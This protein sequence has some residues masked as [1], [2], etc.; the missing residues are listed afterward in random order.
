MKRIGVT[1]DETLLERLD[2]QP[3]VREQ[4]RATVLR[5]AVADYLASK[6]LEAT[7]DCDCPNLDAVE[8]YIMEEDLDTAAELALAIWCESCRSSVE[9]A[10]AATIRARERAEMELDFTAEHL[11]AGEQ[12]LAHWHVMAAL[13][14]S[15]AADVAGEE[16]HRLSLDDEECSDVLLST[17]HAATEADPELR[18]SHL[19]RTIA[20]DLA[21]ENSPIA[22]TAASIARALTEVELA[23]SIAAEAYA[24]YGAA[25]PYICEECRQAEAEQLAAGP[26][27]GQP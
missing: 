9:A 11:A 13:D 4:G 2:Q 18:G 7:A 15:I 27:D 26:S 16:T 25:G 24:V 10:R 20:D 3:E 23:T 1:F 21:A 12:G 17:H 19:W 5:R 6:E 22:P 8:P 14:A